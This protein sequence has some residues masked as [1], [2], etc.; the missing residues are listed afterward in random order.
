MDASPSRSN[1]GNYKEESGPDEQTAYDGWMLITTI[2]GRHTQVQD[3]ECNH[4]GDQLSRKDMGIRS[5]KFLGNMAG[6]TPHHDESESDQNQ[7]D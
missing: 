6:G 2:V 5:I 7:D 3:D 4:D 1:Q